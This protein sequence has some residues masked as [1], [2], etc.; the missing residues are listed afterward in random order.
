MQIE[1]L[2]ISPTVNKLCK[3]VDSLSPDIPDIYRASWGRIKAQ[4]RERALL[5]ERAIIWLTYAYRPL[6]ITELQ[7]GLALQCGRERFDGQDV[8]DEEE[9]VSVSRGLITIEKESRIVR[10]VRE[11]MFL[12]T[13]VCERL[14]VW[15]RFYCASFLQMAWSQPL[16]RTTHIDVNLLYLMPLCTQLFIGQDIN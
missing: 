6:T 1:S 16:L 11:Y 3:A 15:V 2:R 5:A 13:V 12:H 8:A 4:P 10:L 14:M 7:H 9:I